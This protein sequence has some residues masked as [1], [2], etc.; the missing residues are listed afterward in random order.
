M[1]QCVQFYFDFISPYAY[2]GWHRARSELASNGI[3]VEPVPALFAAMLNAN[4][5]KGPAEIPA[6]RLYTWKH[7]IRLAAGLGHPIQPP[8]AH[9]FNPLLSLRVVTALDRL[10]DRISAVDALF[11]ACW[12]RG[13][14]IQERDEVVR[15]L[16]QAGLPGD[17]WTEAAV[18]DE[19]KRRLRD[20]TAG[21]IERGVFG[22][23]SFAAD[24]E[25]FWGQD[26][27]PHVAAYLQGEDPA[28]G[29]VERW[30]NLPAGVQRRRGG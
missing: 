22:V 25:I 2:L 10:E 13:E 30:A 18:N 27:V 11:A 7:V 16:D 28:A 5:T 15:A 26:S 24:D 23:P 21:A 3:T 12:N 17:R 6:K 14:A 1:T 19:V 20:T 4:E 9:P 8:P 29:A